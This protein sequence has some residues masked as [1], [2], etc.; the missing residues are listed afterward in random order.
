MGA[1]GDIQYGLPGILSGICVSILL[2]KPSVIGGG[3]ATAETCGRVK[4]SPVPA[5]RRCRTTRPLPIAVPLRPG[6]ATWSHLP[7]SVRRW[8]P[9]DH[10]GLFGTAC[11]D[12]RRRTAATTAWRGSIGCWDQGGQ[13][14][15]S[16]ETRKSKASPQQPRSRHR[17]Y[18]KNQHTFLGCAGAPR[19]KNLWAKSGPSASSLLIACSVAI[20]CSGNSAAFIRDPV[21][22]HSAGVQREEI[23]A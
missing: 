8:T 13:C 17:R 15:A 2:I 21:E 5:I 19:R 6:D 23:N 3:V 20:L 12:D 1:D 10:T 9:R 14:C 18:S 4:V 22:V 11:E 16:A 7:I